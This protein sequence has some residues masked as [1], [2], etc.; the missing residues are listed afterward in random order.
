MKIVKL[1]ITPNDIKDKLDGKYKDSNVIFT[2]SEIG[3]DNTLTF[4]CIITD[5]DIDKDNKR[6][7]LV[8]IENKSLYDNVRE[9]ADV[10]GITFDEC[11]EYVTKAMELYQTKQKFEVILKGG[12]KLRAKH[13]ISLLEKFDENA[14]VFITSDISNIYHFEDLKKIKD[15][16]ETSWDKNKVNPSPLL[17]ITK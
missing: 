14:E 17:F 3:I 8:Y 9:M 5:E 2:K 7:R 13:L 4:E 10:T 15:V 1:Y 6:E 11:L 16:G 12:L